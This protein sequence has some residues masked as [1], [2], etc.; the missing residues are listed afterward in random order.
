[1]KLEIQKTKKQKLCIIYHPAP[2]TIKEEL[3]EIKKIAEGIEE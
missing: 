1:M 3:D 2:E